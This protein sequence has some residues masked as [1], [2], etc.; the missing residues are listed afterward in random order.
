MAQ[1]LAALR[2]HGTGTGQ[3]DRV[4]IQIDDNAPGP[5]GSA[6]CD[7]GAG[8]F[9]IEFWIRGTLAENAT[10]GFGGGVEVTG[11][12][13]IFGNML[14]DR[15]IWGSSDADWGISVAGGRVRF[16]TGRGDP[17]LGSDTESTIEGNAVV[18]D[19]TWRHIACVRDIAT[20][21]KRIF[22]DGVLDFESVAL[23]SFDDLSYPNGGV[24]GSV[25]PWNPYIVLGAEKH[26]AGSS[27]PSFRGWMDELRIWS[28]ARS[29]EEIAASRQLVLPPGTPGLVGQYR[30][31]EGSGTVVADSSG[32]GSPSGQLIAGVAGNGEW[33]LRSVDPMNTAPILDSGP[34]PTL[35]VTAVAT[36]FFEPTCIAALPDGRLLIGQR[37]GV[38]R[39]Y[40]DDH[41]HGPPVIELPANT[42]NG[43]RGLVGLVADPAFERNG[44]FYAYWTTME[45][46]NRVSRF[47]L[48][49][50]AASPAS[51][52]VLWQNTSLAADWHHG[53]AITF[54]PDG[55]LHIF[56]GDQFNSANSQN[57][58]NEH[59]KVLRINPD[60]TIPADNPFV[61]VPGAAPTIYALGLRNPFRAVHDAPTG[62]LLIGDVGG[63]ASTSWE[64]LNVLLG[65]GGAGAGANFGW[66]NQEGP[67]CFVGDCASITFPRWAYRHDDPNYFVGMAQGSIIAGPVC[68]G[69]AFPP[70]WQGSQL[71]GD[72]ANRWLRRVTF[73]AAGSV[74]A[75][76]IVVKDAGTIVDIELTPD[77]SFWWITHGVPW[78]G[79][80]DPATLWRG[81]FT[82]GN[83]APVVQI[84]AKPTEGP[85]PLLVSFSSAGSFDPDD[86]PKPLSYLWN[87]GDGTTSELPNPT[88][89]YRTAG[90]RLVTL[91]V[92]DGASSTTSAPLL[93]SV[94]TP[95]VPA[96]SAPSPGTM[97][98]AGQT[99]AFSGSAFDPD[100]GAL[101]ESALS[102]SVVLHHLDHT[103]PFLG[104]INGVS[105][106]SFVVPSSG[107]GPADT[108]FRIILTA[109]DP[110][111]LSASTWVDV[112]PQIALLQL[113]TAPSGIALFLDGDPVITPAAYASTPNFVHAITAQPAVIVDG[114][115]LAFTCWSGSVPPQSTN[116]TLSLTMP[117]GGASVTAHYEVA[118]SQSLVTTIPA[119]VRDADWNPAFGQNLANPYDANGL[120]A[121]RDGD[122]PWEC[123]LAFPVNIPQGAAISSARITV[124]ATSDNLGS[125]QLAIRGYDIG[126]VLP[127]AAGPTRLTLWHPLTSSAVPWSPPAVG[128]GTLYDTPNLASIV[129]E[130][131]DRSDWVAGNHLGFVIDGS[132]TAG[133][134]WRCW[135]NFV[136]GAP[137]TLT[138]EWSVPPGADACAILGDLNGD[139]VVDGN[140]LG[141]L[142][143]QWGPCPGCSADL[144]GDGVV[145]GGDLGTLLG[146]WTG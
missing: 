142:L 40:H 119:H 94:G 93:I 7:V 67:N 26:D 14:V 44:W 146:A 18:L 131:V 126:S 15:D 5:D 24:P 136:S 75:D 109:T 99:I 43:E 135:R 98:V 84:S 110:D 33:A 34:D 66:P 16:G 127:F 124:R 59:G 47:T 112:H 85:P 42:F 49:G 141:T 37:N 2:F 54:G 101:P 139:G 115:T 125:P 61:G 70:A 102:W 52:F 72:Y 111:G 36:G 65:L 138:I 144:N 88:H 132:P 96:I 137:A 17:P 89:T 97:S 128:A 80:A 48:V 31:E 116:P 51:E 134:A 4:R 20:G 82:G 120:C 58:S 91:T 140:D 90:P 107:H 78:S 45:P 143:G 55:R 74:V 87:F 86:G 1:S 10:S 81:R 79:T 105:G 113:D 56:T 21:R 106:G 69:A 73:N 6:P 32:A 100:S 130:I 27:F 8:S 23:L 25:T 22:V 35:E 30:F 53:G 108:F 46:R 11:P 92:S 50:E 62:R 118:D 104:P 9:T 28:V 122:G 57:L 103:H 123:G 95:P 64:E 83:L 41:L 133:D 114:S 3:Q 129:Q 38:I 145:N 13:W 29:P 68:R 117:A 12:A 71:I 60:G 121:G 19:G 63:N 76:E 39:L 77:G